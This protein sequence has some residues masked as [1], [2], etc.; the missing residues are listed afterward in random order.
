MITLVKV[1]GTMQTIEQQGQPDPEYLRK[2]IDGY[3]AQVPCRLKD[4]QIFCDEDAQMKRLPINHKISK[5]VGMV[6]AGDCVALSG[7][8]K[9]KWG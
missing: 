5:I 7:K 1:N 4:T 2:L 3:L 8:N 9:I 6:I